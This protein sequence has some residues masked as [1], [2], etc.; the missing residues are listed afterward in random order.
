METF[1]HIMST[2]GAAI[3]LP[4][5]ILIFEICLGVKPS[6][7]VRS[8]IYIGIG[9]NGLIAILNPFFLGLMG[10]AV[11]QMVTESGLQ[12]P[13]I[14]T[15]WALLAAVG[16]STTIGAIIIP[17]GIIV[18]LLLIALKVT[19]TLNLDIWNFWH[20][21]FVGTL[22][23][24]GTGSFVAGILTA[25]AM[26]VFLLVAADF[27]AP[28][29]QEH[30]KL[31]EI[32]FPHASGQGG[33]FTA[34]PLKWL[35]DK[36]GLTKFNLNTSMIR[37]KFGIFGDSVVIGFLVAALIGLIAYLNELTEMET[38]SNILTMGMGTG[39][40]IYLYPKATAALLEG[41]AA[42]NDKVRDKLTK[43]GSNRKLNFGMDSALTVGHPDVITVG[44]LGMITTV[45]LVFFLPGNRFLML[46]NL[47]VTPF[48]L[49]GVAVAIF[50][51]NIIA[52]YITTT[53]N[54][55]ITLWMSSAISPH[56]AAV[57][58]EVGLELPDTGAGAT[59]GA[60]MRPVHG[61]FYYIGQNPIVIVIAII[62]FMFLGFVIKKYPEKTYGLIGVKKPE[63]VDVEP[64]K[65]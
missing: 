9:L 30:F 55:A 58:Q 35:F 38:W 5:I 3:L 2:F 7:A 28:A 57:V 14:D 37:K 44:L 4:I 62:F 46:A 18:N 20:W 13:Y 25:I 48:F 59:V 29:F 65:E 17:V 39:A 31:P 43:R 12:L 47:G 22:I 40:F 21:A 52:S 53:I 11:S 33:I 64:I 63:E 16:Y 56:F 6:K 32:A 54:I 27:T 45:A 10:D 36:I 26:E 34:I 23:Y 1:Q 60:D 41:F 51:G 24:Y 8:A 19:D 42:L 49:A 50:K 61:V 15:G